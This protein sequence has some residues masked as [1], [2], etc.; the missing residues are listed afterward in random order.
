MKFIRFKNRG[1]VIFEGDQS[2]AEFAKM[3]GDEVVSAGFVRSTLG[4]E[5]GHIVCTGESNSLQRSAGGGDSA[6]LTRRLDSA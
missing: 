5:A 6:A 1:F 2:H 4:L 3:I